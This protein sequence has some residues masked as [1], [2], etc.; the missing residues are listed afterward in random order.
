MAVL[1]LAAC[2]LACAAG[3]CAGSLLTRRFA[4]RPKHRISVAA[5]S[6]PGVSGLDAACLAYLVSTSKRVSLHAT[7]LLSRRLPLPLRRA[8]ASFGACAEKAGLSGRANADGYCE[9]ALRLAFAGAAGGALLGAVASNELAIAGC[10]AG[11]LFGASAPRRAVASARKARNLSLERSLSEMLEVVA[12]GIRSGLSFDRSMQLY[13]A[14]FDDALSRECASAL[15]LW[16]TGMASRG[17]ALRSLAASYDSALLSRMVAA[18]ARSLRFGTSLG[19]V[20]E[21]AAGE[22]RVSRRAQ[23]EERVAKAP[24]KMMIPTGVLILPAML[25][26]VLGPV[27]LELMEGM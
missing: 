1:A 5:P 16:E 25:L 9:A 24:V 27:L 19:D 17:D 8:R 20:L 6:F 7:S 13:A 15:Q 12:L 11:A 10:A 18:I 4:G 14:H 22:A 23:V 2:V 21:Q 3:A 26:L